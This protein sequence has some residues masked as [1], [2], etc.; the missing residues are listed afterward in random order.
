[1]LNRFLESLFL[2]C[3][4]CNILLLFLDSSVIVCLV[5]P[6]DQRKIR[7]YSLIFLFLVSGNK[8]RQT[9]EELTFH[10]ATGKQFCGI[11]CLCRVIA[12]YVVVLLYM[13]RGVFIR[14]IRPLWSRQTLHF[15]YTKKKLNELL[16]DQFIKEKSVLESVK[17]QL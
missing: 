17:K 8:E 13:I 1:M 10:G 5:F 16:W 6:R 2:G 15:F 11:Q 14:N 7:Q 3:Y 4:R 12:T 9:R